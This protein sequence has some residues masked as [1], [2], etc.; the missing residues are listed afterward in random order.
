MA[1]YET[2]T[3][4]DPGRW[5]ED[6]CLRI[7]RRSDRCSVLGPGARAVI[8][9]QGCPFRCPG[10]IA[11]LELPFVGG[12]KVAVDDLARELATLDVEGVTFSGGEPFAQALSLARLVMRLKELRP[13]F[14]FMSY[15]GYTIETLLQR[16]SAAQRALLQ[17]LD[18]L[19]DGLYVQSRHTDL[20]WR[21]SDNQRVLF[22]TPR[23]RDW[24]RPA[25]ERG[26]WL[27]FE[28]EDDG[29]RVMGI[30]PQ[31]FMEQ[32]SGSMGEQGV[33]LIEN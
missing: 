28:T 5:P 21:G 9:V 15:S 32:L 6:G 27:E 12:K 7:A 24:E 18:L 2:P 4:T 26:T 16:G 14:G 31:G 22:L 17:Q 19:V 1:D 3:V 8:W 29:F 10:C 30:L 23:Y 25:Q 20:K 13:D 11:P 33:T